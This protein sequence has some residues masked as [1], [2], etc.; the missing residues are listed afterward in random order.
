MFDSQAKFPML[1]LSPGGVFTTGSNLSDR[2]DVLPI[3]TESF[4][5]LDLK[6]ASIQSIDFLILWPTEYAHIIISDIFHH[7]I[8]AIRK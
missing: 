2:D 3:D 5:M 6:M 4:K 7:L 1:R 8:F